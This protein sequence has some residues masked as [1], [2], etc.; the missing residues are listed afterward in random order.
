V[1]TPFYAHEA[2]FDAGMAHWLRVFRDHG[3][4]PREL[5]RPER[6]SLAGSADD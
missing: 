6:A 3:R 5:P 2:G 4:P 1:A